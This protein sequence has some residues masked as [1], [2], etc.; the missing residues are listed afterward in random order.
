MILID[1]V[2]WTDG[3]SIQMCFYYLRY[4]LVIV[5]LDRAAEYYHGESVCQRHNACRAGQRGAQR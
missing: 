5:W 3:E 4:L 1:I 2:V